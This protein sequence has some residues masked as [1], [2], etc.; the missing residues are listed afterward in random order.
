MENVKINGPKIWFVTGSSRGFGR[1]WTEAALQR[2]DKVAATARNIDSIADFKDKYGDNVLIL[3]L[4]VTNGEQ[5]QKAVKA[6]H[7]Y[8]GRLDVVINNAGYSLVGTVEEAKADDILA[9][10]KTNVLGPVSV[11]QAVLPIMRAQGFGH[12]L[13]TSSSLGHYTVP[14]IGYYCS[15]KWAFEAIY[16]SLAV[17]VKS[18]G[19]HVSIIEPGAY[20][21]EFGSE[22]S[23]QFSENLPE[24]EAVRNMVFENMGKMQRGNPDATAKAVLQLVDTKNPPLRM[25]LGSHNLEEIRQVYS[26]RIKVWEAWQDVAV[27]AQG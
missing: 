10:Y 2:G 22:N 15:S 17:E 7:E 24:Y 6:A 18:F 26:D 4:D 27:A 12:I 14:L 16:E 20:A 19:I 13:G 21:T 23:L 5:V 25:F 11:I 8:F 3:P 9:M 1:V